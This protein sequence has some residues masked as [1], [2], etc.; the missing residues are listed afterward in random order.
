MLRSASRLFSSAAVAAADGLSFKLSAEQAAIQELARNF[1]KTEMIPKA[2]HHDR[3][4]EYP[5]AVFKKAWDAGLLNSHIPVEYGGAGLGSIEGVI[6]AEELAYGCSGMS[7]AIEANGL[8]CA[9]LII[10]ASHDLKKKYLGRLTEEPLKASYCVT[11]P[12]AGS[13]VAGIKTR[14]EKKGNEYILNGTKM[15][16]TGVRN[17]TCSCSHVCRVEMALIIRSPHSARLLPCSSGW[18]CELVFCART[19]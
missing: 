8:G 15:W 6:V 4:G 3:T 9:P 14:A 7:T 19:H 11:E 12:G 2:A 10:A 1:A 13:D 18:R 16:I 5:E 17:A